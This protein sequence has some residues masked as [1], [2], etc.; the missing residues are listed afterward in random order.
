MYEYDESVF[1][2]FI[3]V[4][5]DIDVTTLTEKGM[6]AIGSPTLKINF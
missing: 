2:K 5:K 3:D 1:W 6:S 4:V